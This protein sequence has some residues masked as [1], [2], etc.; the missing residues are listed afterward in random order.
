MDRY[1]RRRLLSLA[2]IGLAVLGLLTL[3]AVGARSLPGTTRSLALSWTVD[4]IQ[5][6]QIGIGLVIIAA[7][8]WGLVSSRRGR[9]EDMPKRKTTLKRQS[10]LAVFLVILAVALLFYV[11]PRQAPEVLDE[12]APDIN[13][14]EVDFLPMENV[15]AGWPLLALIATAVIAAF[16]V[17][18]L[19]R[20]REED[21]ADL[22]AGALVA[23]TLT[24]ALDELSWSD[25]PRSVIIKA[26]HDIEAAL[27]RSGLPRRPS[28]APREY[29]ERVLATVGVGA[30][31]ITRLTALFELARFSEHD[32]GASE[33]NEAEAALRS[34]LADLQVHS[35]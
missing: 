19:S 6:I 7:I 15:G 22:D 3:T 25:D 4:V 8:I 16:A 27:A 18:M 11:I 30:E 13:I 20:Q 23:G 5:V 29:L 12:S 28:E 32:L 14:S 26:Y 10:P 34:A 33:T 17:S 21:E 9:E 31:S 2:V 24:G 1:S 35:P